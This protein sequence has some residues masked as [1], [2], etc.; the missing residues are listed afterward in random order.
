MK[1][2]VVH[3]TCMHLLLLVISNLLVQYPFLVLGF[4]T[5]WGAL[6]YPMIFILTDLT[7][8][9]MGAK[10][11]RQTLL[12]ALFPALLCSWMI[13]SWINTGYLFSL[14][15]VSLRIAGA[16]LLAYLTGQWLDISIF[17]R[18]RKRAAW[19]VAPGASTVFGNALDTFLFFFVAFFH[20]SNPF[21]ASHWLEIALVDLAFKWIVTLSALIPLYGFLLNRLLRLPLAQKPNYT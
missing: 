20:S 10:V 17:N 5:T 1:L 4:H 21:L 19:W 11:A 7:T 8:R 12:T 18:L 9:L 13:S 16:S 3:L 14:E 6:T 2:S 15:S